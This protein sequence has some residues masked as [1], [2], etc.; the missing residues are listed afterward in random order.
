MV[1][2]L[3][4][5][6]GQLIDLN[7][8]ISD[9]DREIKRLNDAKNNYQ[10]TLK[11]VNRDLKNSMISGER[12]EDFFVDY[13]LF[14]YG[15][16]GIKMVGAV[17]EFFEEFEKFK[18]QLILEDVVGYTL[19]MPRGQGIHY[20]G[21]QKVGRLDKDNAL[22][23]RIVI[24]KDR[25]IYTTNID[26]LMIAKDGRDFAE[27]GGNIIGLNEY[28]D[29]FAKGNRTRLD[30]I[31]GSSTIGENGL[32]IDIRSPIHPEA[33]IGGSK[34]YDSEPHQSL[35]VGDKLVRKYFDENPQEVVLTQKR[36]REIP[37]I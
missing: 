22:D 32:R 12:L 19:N 26:P 20:G 21:Y 23:N 1:Q 25:M 15:S 33:T 7:R 30:E 36:T 37:F 29:A 10:E 2:L 5:L 34:R 9:V 13:A 16:D 18:G 11:L 14:H 28:I 27:S 17:N 35:I 4:K 24:S 6:Y 8:N 31:F 3:D